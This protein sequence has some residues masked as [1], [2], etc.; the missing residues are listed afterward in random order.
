MAAGYDDMKHLAPIFEYRDDLGQIEILIF[1]NDVELI[2]NHHVIGR[3]V[4]H[5]HGLSPPFNGGSHI[6]FAIL[7][8]PS[9]T[10]ADGVKIALRVSAEKLPLRGIQCALDELHHP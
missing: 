10:G 9:V 7:R 1:E 3:I 5:A 8:I 2:E 6:R 4:D